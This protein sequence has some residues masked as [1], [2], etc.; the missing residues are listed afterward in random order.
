VTKVY[1]PEEWRPKLSIFVIFVVLLLALY[2]IYYLMVVMYE[3]LN[4]LPKIQHVFSAARYV[5]LLPT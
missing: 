5:I 3:V 4:T 2:L 1:I